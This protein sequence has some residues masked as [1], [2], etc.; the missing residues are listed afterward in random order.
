MVPKPKSFTARRLL[1]EAPIRTWDE[2]VPLGN[3]LLGLLLW[4]GEGFIQISLDRADLWDHRV[5]EPF[6]REDWNWKNLKALVHEKKWCEIA[7]RFINPG[8]TYAY[9]T[10]LPAGRL[11][12]DLPPGR[13]VT[14]FQL[15]R[16][17]A[18]GSAKWRGGSLEAFCELEGDVACLRYR[19]SGVK[20]RL[21]PPPFT[22]KENQQ[23]NGMGFL[24]DLVMLKYPKASTW[25]SGNV[26]GFVQETIADGA[27]A[28]AVAVQKVAGWTELF[29]AV[30]LGKNREAARQKAATAAFT[31]CNRGWAGLFNAHRAEWTRLWARSQ[32]NLPDASLM[33]QYRQAT[34]F[35]GSVSRAGGPPISL[36]AVWTADDGRLPPWKGDYHH[37]LNTQLSYWPHLTA[38]H[39]DRIRGF[40]DFMM[41]LAPAHRRL[42]RRFFDCEGIFIPG[43]M[44]LDGQLIGGYAQVSY[45]PT[46]GAWVAQ[47]FYQYWKYTLDR[48]FLKTHAYPYCRGTAELLAG[49]LEKG[50]DGKLCLPLSASPEIHEGAPAGWVKPNANYD[51]ALMRWNFAA[52]AEMARELDESDLKWTKILWELEP[53]AVANETGDEIPQ[54]GIGP[55]LI[56]PE[57]LLHESHRHHSHLMGIY[58]LGLVSV[59]D[60]MNTRK[61][62]EQSFHQIDKLGTGLWVGYSFAWMACLAARCKQPERARKALQNFVEAFVS[63]NGFHLNGDHKKLGLSWWNYRPF[64]LEGNFAFLAGVHEM[65]LQSWRGVVR[66]FPAVPGDWH[67]VSF[68]KLRAEGALVVSATRRLGKT[69]RV[70]I[71]AERDCQVRLR[72]PFL[73]KAKWNRRVRRGE[74]LIECTLKVGETLKGTSI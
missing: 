43:A 74:A 3:G 40:L 11:F 18:L 21:E 58:P 15:D 56:A 67:E 31:A 1:L 44:A 52:V 17:A 29:V 24:M 26:S 39:E 64:T 2:A 55:F 62:I 65:L 47:L 5:P 45:S 6:T 8:Q 32:V 16:D 53:L 71:R 41:K 19:G 20:W 28:V 22:R 30:E 73:T 57:K 42:A 27:F 10:K 61:A 4:G 23:D 66:I 25:Q 37:N 60:D 63:R 59:E 9:P 34:Y 70:E 35:L 7:T 14:V 54:P 50:K 46:N 12:L 72:D 13:S 69:A 38:G 49:L 51:L 48:K 68:E 36:Q 33:D